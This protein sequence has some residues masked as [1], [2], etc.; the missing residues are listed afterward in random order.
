M[1]LFEFFLDFFLLR[2]ELGVK[3]LL[4]LF[5]ADGLGFV[6]FL[7]DDAFAFEPLGY[8]LKVVFHREHRLLDLID[9][10]L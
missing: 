2:V 6:A 8:R 10:G 4:Q 3:G 1:N 7:D 9:F 5:V